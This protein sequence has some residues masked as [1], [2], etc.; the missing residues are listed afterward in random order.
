VLPGAPIHTHIHKDLLLSSPFSSSSYPQLNYTFPR[1]QCH[2]RTGITVKSK[3]SCV[4]YDRSCC[5]WDSRGRRGG[6][7]P[8]GQTQ[9]SSQ[10]CRCYQA[11]HHTHERSAGGPT[12]ATYCPGAQTTSSLTRHSQHCPNELIAVRSSRRRTTPGPENGMSGVSARRENL[13]PPSGFLQ[14]LQQNT[15]MMS[16]TKAR[17]RLSTSSS[18]PDWLGRCATRREF[19]GSRLDEVNFSNLPNPS[20]RTSTRPWGL[21]S[22]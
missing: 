5:W 2:E 1:A 14:S 8:R 4:M 16:E 13:L 11:G 10:Q 15:T 22:L 6:S 20:C 18:I 9:P 21:L 7:G 3:L 19:A 17:T 12:A